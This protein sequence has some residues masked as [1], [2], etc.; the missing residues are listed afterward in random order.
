MY[1][2]IH[3]MYNIIHAIYDIIHAKYNIIHAMYII[4]RLARLLH[5]YRRF[6]TAFNTAT[7]VARI[8][9]PCNTR[10]VLHL[11]VQYE[12]RIARPSATRIARPSAIHSFSEKNW[13]GPS[14]VRTLD[15]WIN[16]QRLYLLSYQGSCVKLFQNII[17]I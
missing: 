15:P 3:A 14:E 17:F 10:L 11:A 4:T 7:K 13:F 5:E 9:R 1:N 16:R 8:A 6:G 12:S 2:I